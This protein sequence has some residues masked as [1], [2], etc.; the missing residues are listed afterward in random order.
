MMEE[1]EENN[2]GENVGQT[3]AVANTTANIFSDLPCR[4][5]QMLF[6]VS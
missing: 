1:E 6:D 5:Q 3:K 2:E 4:Q